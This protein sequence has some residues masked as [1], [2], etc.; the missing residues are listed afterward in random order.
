L[1]F[2]LSSRFRLV[3]RHFLDCSDVLLHLCGSLA[4]LEL[5]TG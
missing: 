2:I 4:G 1:F 3:F 5:L